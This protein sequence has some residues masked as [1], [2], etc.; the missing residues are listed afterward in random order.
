[1]RCAA[2]CFFFFTLFIYLFIFWSKKSSQEVSNLKLPPPLF[3]SDRKVQY[4]GIDC[5]S[6]H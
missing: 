4:V 3:F 1:M 6:N 2:L 5:C